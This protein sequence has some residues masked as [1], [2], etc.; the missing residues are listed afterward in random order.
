[1]TDAASRSR[2]P[3]FEIFGV[4][5]LPEVRP[6]D[7]LGRL[8]VDAAHSQRTPL[9]RGDIVQKVGG[10]FKLSTLIP[11]ETAWKKDKNDNAQR[12]I[13][14]VASKKDGSQLNG[15]ISAKKDN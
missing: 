3:R 8:V 6:G 1:M 2:P 9:E 12:R 5:G 7:D 10:R 14:C 13:Y 4:E 11:T 15:T